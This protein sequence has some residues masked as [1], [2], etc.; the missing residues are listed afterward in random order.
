MGFLSDITTVMGIILVWLAPP[1]VWTLVIVVFPKFFSDTLLRAID[2]K[3]NIRLEEI[4][5]ELARQNAIEIEMLKSDDSTLKSS[6]ELLSANQGEI[7]ARR[8]VAIEKMWNVFLQMDRQFAGLIYLDTILLPTELDDFFR[9]NR[10]KPSDYI[11]GIVRQYID[12]DAVVKKFNESGAEEIEK[13]RPFVGDQ[14]WKTFYALRALYGRCA[15]LIK[16]SFEKKRYQNWKEDGHFASVV[17]TAVPPNV[18]DAAK[19]RQFQG[20]QM[21]ILH[22]TQAFLKESEHV[23]SGTRA[24]AEFIPNIQEILMEERDKLTGYRAPNAD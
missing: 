3:H 20:L 10:K 5:S 6:V 18:M 24:A 11:E 23:L 14:I 15:I 8:L 4:K 9:G 2:H 21:I 22:L 12:Q 1:L 19:T 13:E 17:G 16:Y 7:R